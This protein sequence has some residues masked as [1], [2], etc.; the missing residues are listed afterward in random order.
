MFMTD[1]INFGPT[2]KRLRLKAGMTLDELCA[3]TD[4]VIQNGYLSQIERK[5]IAISFN[6]LNSIS[7]AL[8]ISIADM[9]REA[10][11]GEL[12]EFS[13]NHIPI[14]D[15]KGDRTGAMLAVPHDISPQCFALKVSNN[16][17]ESKTGGISYFQGGYVI[18]RPCNELINERDYV[19]RIDE[20][21]TAARY[22]TDGRRSFLNYL[23]PSFPPE[24]LPKEPDL[25]GEIIG[26]FFF[27]K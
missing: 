13:G 23:N 7:K 26:F 19:F 16:S 4:F 9:I 25:K 6:K 15:E 27:S 12:V 20:Y 21:L 11:G 3:A 22:Q 18:V 10:E 2:I 17:M 1:N 24:T 5:P 8:G 14:R